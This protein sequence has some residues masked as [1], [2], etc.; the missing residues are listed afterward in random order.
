MKDKILDG[1]KLADKLNL[2][3]K[4]KISDLVKETGV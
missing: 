4:N 2:E 3:L 1:K